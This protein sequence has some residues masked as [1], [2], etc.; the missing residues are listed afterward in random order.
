MSARKD[1]AHVIPQLTSELV[2]L[3][4]HDKA[5]SPTDRDWFRQMASLVQETH[6][7]LYYRRLADLK[8]A[9][10]PFDPDADTAPLLPVSSD[11]KQKR[12][13]ELQ[14]NLVT[15]LDRAH[16]RHLN[17]G[18]MEPLLENASEW[19]IRMAVDFSIF[20]HVAVFVR[21]EGWQKRKL[22]NW[23]TL[24]LEQEQEVPIY[25][26]LV[27]IIKFR[28]SPRL[29]P[30]INT[31]PVYLKIF[32]DIPCADVDMLL[33]G[34][35][36]RLKLIDR[37]KIGFGLFS[38]LATILYRSLNEVTWMLDKLLQSDK[39]L[40]GLA[41]GALGYGYKSYFDYQTT[42]QSY[43]LNLTQSLY[44]QCLDSNAG[45]LTRLLDEAEE[46]ETRTTLLA[47]YALWRHAPPA[48]LTSEDV[49]AAME[50]F[51]DRYANVTLL[52]QPGEPIA[53]LARLRLVET[54]GQ[55]YRS[56]PLPRALQILQNLE[57][58]R[59]GNDLTPLAQSNHRV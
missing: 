26:R 29:G 9:Y 53:K 4:C 17:R 28:P 3:V 42:R 41:A 56:V 50:L 15:L 22:R 24:F 57:S 43:H 34:A 39:T 27:L 19:G 2:E 37:S 52:C 54:T 12:L 31:D 46:Q 18:E 58:P 40:W 59:F 6:H 49:E 35:R 14:R 8:N 16:Y 47:Y 38:G 7:R 55:C 10:A 30:E 13:N 20:D 32:K 44:F 25:R 33:P 48:G 5:L 23:K 36:V 21:G 51:L 11:L 45:V 1:C